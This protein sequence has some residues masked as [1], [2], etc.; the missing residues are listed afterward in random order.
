MSDNTLLDYIRKSREAGIDDASIKQTLLNAGWQITDVQTAIETV[1]LV[2]SISGRKKFF[3]FVLIII[4]IVLI[5]SGYFVSAKFYFHTWPFKTTESVSVF[6]PKPSQNQPITATSTPSN[7]PSSTPIDTKIPTP[8]TSPVSLEL[9]SC[10]E[11]NKSGKYS[12]VADI[13]N[14]KSEPCIKVQNINNVSLDCQNH[15]ITSKNENYNIYVKG[16]SDFKINNCKL[17]S[18]VNVSADV[19][20]QHVLRIEDS[21][22]GEVY[23]NIIGGNF[24]SISGATAISV[25]DNAFTNQLSVYQSNHITITSNNISNGSDPLHLEGGNNNSVISNIIDGKSDGIFANRIGAD[26][27][28][29]PRDESQDLIQ[30]NTIQNVF[31]CGIENVGSIFDSKIIG[32][33][34]KNAGFC[35]IGGWYWS[36]VKGNLI[37]DNIADNTPQLFHFAR[38]YSLKSGEQYVYFKD[39]TFENNKF[40]NPRTVIVR[41]GG[42]GFENASQI[43]IEATDV[44]SSSIIV[45]NNIFLNNDFTIV[46]DP[47]LFTPENMIIDGGGNK[48]P[49]TVGTNFPLKCN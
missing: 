40:V 37:K 28:I 31:D 30:E 7:I 45:G 47:I 12:L 44:P 3:H 25:H 2:N 15:T 10:G 38:T 42:Y 39:N 18:S 19:S 34:I 36:S 17:V 16:V 33:N 26:D 21:K 8:T 32:N 5:V 13:T 1:N 4:S 41:G 20:S 22:Q 23:D 11:I 48:C 9:N 27:G 14:T 43:T 29:V 35:G 24:T 46:A 6:T 49:T